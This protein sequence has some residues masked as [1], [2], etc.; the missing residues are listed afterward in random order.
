VTPHAGGLAL[1]HRRAGGDLEPT[2]LLLLVDQSGTELSDDV[3]FDDS[4]QR[5]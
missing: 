4:G 2:E 1:A 5:R 3:L